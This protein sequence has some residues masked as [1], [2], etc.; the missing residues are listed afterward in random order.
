M[1]NTRTHTHTQPYST[2]SEEMF[3]MSGSRCQV[4]QGFFEIKGSTVFPVMGTI[5]MVIQREEYTYYRGNPAYYQKHRA[6]PRFG[7]AQSPPTQ[8]LSGCA[9]EMCASTRLCWQ[10]ARRELKGASWHRKTPSSNAT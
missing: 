2:I 5:I 6:H 4:L 9:A 8:L 7:E 1:N 3:L 10:T